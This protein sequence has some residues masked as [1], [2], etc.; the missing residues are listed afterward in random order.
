MKRRK[1]K[2]VVMLLYHYSIRA[3]MVCRARFPSCMLRILNP[4]Q[5]DNASQRGHPAGENVGN[6][7]SGQSDKEPSELQPLE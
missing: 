3:S 5:P 1:G 6:V 2:P 4:G 7:Q